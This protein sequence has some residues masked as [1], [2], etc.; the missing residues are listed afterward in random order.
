MEANR[1]VR[2]QLE[3]NRQ[4]RDAW[5][6]YGPHRARVTDVVMDGLAPGGRVCILGA[7]NVND[8]D[9][10]RILSR[11]RSV[12]LLD[13]DGE[14][15]DAGRRRQG[16]ASDDRLHVHADRDLSGVL[17][18]LGQGADVETLA[19]ALDNPT[20][21]PAGTFDVALSVGVLTQLFQSVVDAGLEPEAT[22]DLT[23]RLRR[24]H[25]LELTRL[26]RPGGGAVLVTDTA[27]T[28]TA[29]SLRHLDQAELEPAMAALVAGGNF[30]TGTNAY[31]V[32][33]VLEEDEAFAGLVSEVTLHDPWL[34][35]VTE[36]REHLT[37]AVT[38]RRRL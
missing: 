31:R 36:D 15:M 37:Y 33:A 38:W 22:V 12:D 11:A 19:H 1:F 32:V 7:G 29:P 4:S 13:L 28:S 8:V 18:L 35:A 23:L 2:R 21:A 16:L 26:A 20:D 3:S 9:L 17:D 30:F 6:R 14:A 27:P 5:T 34:W 24:R 10:A 25:L